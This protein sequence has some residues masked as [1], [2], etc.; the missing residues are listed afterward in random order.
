MLSQ[1]QSREK[2]AGAPKTYSNIVGPLLWNE[3]LRKADFFLGCPL[4]IRAR[5]CWTEFIH[6]CPQAAY[7]D[8][9]VV[10]PLRCVWLPQTNSTDPLL[11]QSVRGPV[12]LLPAG[13]H[14]IWTWIFWGVEWCNNDFWNYCLTAWSTH[15]VLNDEVCL[16]TH[17]CIVTNVCGSGQSSHLHA[18][19][20]LS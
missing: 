11:R 10:Q 3:D 8:H 16:C 5:V 9:R 14:D 13:R 12:D 18:V 4:Y 20:S 15:I 1:K 2:V 6:V 19:T 17:V 7:P